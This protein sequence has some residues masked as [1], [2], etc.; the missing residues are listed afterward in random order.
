MTELEDKEK[1]VAATGAGFEE[2]I[3]ELTDV[4]DDE[5]FAQW[6][7][8]IG[9]EASVSTFELPEEAKE[10]E[11]LRPKK[12][13]TTETIA[14]LYVKQGYLDKAVDIYQAIYDA[15]PE[16]EEIKRKLHELKRRLEVG[17][18]ES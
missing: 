7:E 14:E 6:E 1:A 9:S 15:H 13:I 3:I 18:H 5:E 16:D 2:E 11:E 8:E 17:S 4:V 10:S 12:E